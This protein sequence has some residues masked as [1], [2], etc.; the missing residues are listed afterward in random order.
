MPI[1]NRDTCKV[2]HGRRR[3]GRITENQICAG[4]NGPDTCTA[5][6]VI[7]Y[8][9]LYNSD[10]IV[11]QMLQ[12]PGLLRFFYYF[13]YFPGLL[14]FFRKYFLFRSFSLGI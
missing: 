7:Y 5:D 9:I 13:F 1:I 2:D 12:F 3:G 6:E 10:S 8:T 4:G 14:H 11:T